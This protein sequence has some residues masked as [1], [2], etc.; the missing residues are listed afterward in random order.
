MN[1]GFLKEYPI[2]L[3][4][5]K[6]TGKFA[7]VA[8]HHRYNAVKE[9]IEEGLLSEDFKIPVIIKN[10]T[11]EAERT[12]D[13]VHENSIRREVNPLD[14]AK[15]FKKMIDG[16]MPIERI[17]QKLGIRTK[18]FIENRL[19]LNNLIPQI[20]SL[21]SQKKLPLK[22]AY[23][24]GKYGLNEDGS[25]NGTYQLEALKFFLKN[26]NK[27]YGDSHVE[28]FMLDFISKQNFNL[29]G[30]FGL[31]E[32]EFAKNKIKEKK[33]EATKKLFDKSIN[34]LLKIKERLLPSGT[35]QLNQKIIKELVYSL[36]SIGGENEIQK[37]LKD[38]DILIYSLNYLK[39][40]VEKEYKKLK[41][42][43]NQKK[44]N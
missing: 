2:K 43:I 34:D 36:L 38:L 11:S 1:E 22:V 23:V 20:K 40:N 9:L 5:N 4:Y 41:I 31:Q 19:A 33:A 7:I 24:I 26:R 10:Y 21:I 35:N 28:S 17:M 16:G 32:M 12:L 18:S 14:E 13:Q 39:N 15:A 3:D 29:F 8:G 6:E 44:E 42:E 30:S 37:K 27:G 25:P